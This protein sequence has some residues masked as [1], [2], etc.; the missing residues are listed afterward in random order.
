MPGNR[1]NVVKLLADHSEVC[2]F[3]SSLQD[4]DNFKLVRVN[5]KDLYKKAL[6]SGD[7]GLSMFQGQHLKRHHES[8][9]SN[10]KPKRARIADQTD[11]TDSDNKSCDD[12][13]DDEGSS[14]DSEKLGKEIYDGNPG[15]RLEVVYT[16]V[17][18]GGDEEDGR[19]EDKSEEDESE[20]NDC[21][22][23]NSREEDSFDE[24]WESDAP[25]RYRFQF[26]TLL[27]RDWH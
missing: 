9:S 21:G 3:G 10:S 1:E 19:G 11:T 25:R 16:D 5:I 26:K 6:A 17:E 12:D 18:D 20:E 22:E 15:D 13:N 23:E 24:D 2:K 7:K 4:Q 27:V 14:D 8:D